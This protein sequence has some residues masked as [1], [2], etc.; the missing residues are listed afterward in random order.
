MT[1]TELSPA[2]SALAES[3]LA[4]PALA[5]SVLANE[6]KR[7]YLASCMKSTMAAAAAAKIMPTSVSAR[8]RTLISAPLPVHSIALQSFMWDCWEA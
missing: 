4:E 3:A 1:Q 8:I 5:E 6:V 7:N 2:A